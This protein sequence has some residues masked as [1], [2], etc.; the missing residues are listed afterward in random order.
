[1]VAV[2]SSG[3]RKAALSELQIPTVVIHGTD[4]PLVPVE[5]G[6][7]MADVVPGAELAL[8]EGMGHDLP[9]GAWQTVADAITSNA[10]RTTTV[11]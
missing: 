8:I 1:M 4:D 9:S 5:N 3:G 10:R 7:K 6:R 11:G 2:M